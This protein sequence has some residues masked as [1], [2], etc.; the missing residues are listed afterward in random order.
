MIVDSLHVVRFLELLI[1]DSCV[2]YVG[3]CN[4]HVV[5]VA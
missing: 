2:E 5:G 3:L 4:V 1:R